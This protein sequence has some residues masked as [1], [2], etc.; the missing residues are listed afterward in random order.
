MLVNGS[1]VL[2]NPRPG[3]CL[4]S[5]LRQ[6]EWFGVK[7]GCDTGDCGACT[8]WVDGEPVHSCL[9]PAH[10]ATG[11]QVT[12]IEG[13][14]ASA[15]TP[16]PMQARFLAAQGFQCGFCTAG[17]IMTSAYLDRVQCPID[18]EALKSNL[19]RCTGYRAIIDATLGK[20]HVE[21]GAIGDVCG[22]SLRAVSG[23][24]IVSGRARF[25]LDVAMP[26][27]LHMKLLR[28]P[29][30]HA[31]IVSIDSAEALAVPGVYCVLTHQDAP[32]K[33]YSTALVEQAGDDPSDTRLLDD[34]VRFIGQ[35]VA[36]VVA[37]TEA[38]AEYGCGLLR[39]SYD[40]LPAV[41]DPKAAMKLGAPVVQNYASPNV[42]T[43]LHG[44][45]GDVAAGMA[46]AD[47]TY[48]ASFETQRTQHVSL[49]THGAVGWLDESG[50]L[51]LRSSTQAPFLTRRALAALFDLPEKEVY[52]EAGRM[53]G[54]FG[55]KQEM[56]VE[57][58][59]A[60]AVLRCRAP[61]QLELTREEQFSS[62][63][64]RHPMQ[65]FVRVGAMKDGTLTSIGLEVL[66]NTGAYG[67]HGAGVMSHACNESV[68]IYRCP[69]KRVD[70]Y[71]VATNSVPAGAFRGYGLSQTVFAVESAM[72]ELAHRLKLDPITLRR[73]NMVQP[74]DPIIS[75]ERAPPDL[76][77]GSFGLEQCLSMVERALEQDSS[78][79]PGNWCI[80][81][82]V[83][84]GMVE[85][86]PPRGHN[87]NVRLTLAADGFFDLAVGTVEFGNGTGTALVQI[88][89][90]ILGTLPARIR[91]SQSDT[92]MVPY[93]T[94]TYGS[95]S[96]MVAGTATL[97][98]AEALRALICE[99][100]ARLL[101][102]PATSVTLE[103]DAVVTTTERISLTAIGPLQEV[104]HHDGTPRSVS[105]NVHGFRVA[106]QPKTG[107]LRIL[108]SV[109]AADAGH[110]INPLQCRGQIEGGV[111]Q[112]L[113]MALY[114]NLEIDESG[115][116]KNRSLRDYHIPVFGELPETEVLFADTSD[117]FGPFGAKSMS[118][119]P[120][121][122]VA[123][124]LANA[125]RDAIGVRF[126]ATPIRVD[127]IWE[128]L[129]RN[130]DK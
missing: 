114:E 93:D 95:A 16:H 42:L 22:S 9:Y 116:V 124:A 121:N 53:G 33:L 6:N 65:I 117:Q 1:P 101:M 15:G 130:G 5:F 113:G 37:K 77:F 54:A 109:H 84:M 112:A 35:R 27:L 85:T 21:D 45:I 74:G 73:R 48:E 92:D 115:R 125:I 67:N 66:S 46:V 3:Q 90:S 44:G 50:R 24:E 71:V 98:A 30:A 108:R 2:G 72:D 14:E 8:V 19:C 111:A 118:E 120:F 82:G 126:R 105:F 68:G 102:V 123:P 23:L 127:Q 11:R 26:G 60:L 31:R 106:I 36:A 87:A 78:T 18:G 107:E 58:V 94:G 122:P 55:G 34:T 43:E 119:A 104:G 75:L 51:C 47:V 97:R 128:A 69:N 38:I 96:L 89:A 20:A 110:I 70:G 13:L 10:R 79:T 99:C 32:E 88:A 59:V 64:T 129:H 41:F 62:T 39:V 86:I 25:T 49:E 80:G 63:T 100:G 28:S 7:R 57:D 76:R 61:V 83:A 52:V 40:V 56:L 4:C 81:K 91:I 103:L 17:M 12:T 29:H